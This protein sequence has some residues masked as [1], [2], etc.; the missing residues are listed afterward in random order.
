MNIKDIDPNSRVRISAGHWKGRTGRIK[1]IEVVVDIG[2]PLLIRLDPK[3][4]EPVPEDPLPPGWEEV[5]I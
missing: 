1:S 3:D 5:N 2:E 4:L